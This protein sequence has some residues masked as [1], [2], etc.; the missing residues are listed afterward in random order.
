M[1]AAW[2]LA[3][4][5]PW[6]W[7]S[8][9]GSWMGRKAPAS[10]MDCWVVPWRFPK[11]GMTR[12]RS[13]PEL[14]YIGGELRSQNLEQHPELTLVTFLGVYSVLPVAAR[15][16]S[17]GI[18][19]I[20]PSILTHMISHVNPELKLSAIQ[21]ESPCLKAGSRNSSKYSCEPNLVLSR[22]ENLC[23]IDRP[24]GK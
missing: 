21:G 14:Q 7:R 12:R 18:P 22:D 2:P 13:T 11:S 20:L 17:S 24:V 16:V 5:S 1:T 8:V 3:V 9:C 23:T 4:W 15:R 10:S 19:G 6:S